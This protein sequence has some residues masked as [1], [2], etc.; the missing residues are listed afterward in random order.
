VS[1]H[2]YFQRDAASPL[3]V[4]HPPDDFIYGFTN[5]RDQTAMRPPAGDPVAVLPPHA[6]APIIDKDVHCLRGMDSP[7]VIFD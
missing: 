2:I 7:S 4:Y 3:N 5:V 6:P 1:L